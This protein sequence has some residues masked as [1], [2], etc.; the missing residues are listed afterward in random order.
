MVCSLEMYLSIWYSLWQEQHTRQN[1]CNV[2]DRVT[3]DYS[4][5]LEHFFSCPLFIEVLL[6]MCPETIY[7]FIYNIITLTNSMAPEP[8]GSSPHSQQPANGPYPEPGESTPHTHTHTSLPKVHFYPILPSTSWSSKWS[9]SFGISHQNP[10]HVSLLSHACHMSRLPYSPLFDLLN[11]VSWW[12]QIMKLS[13]LQLSPLSRYFIPL[14]SK[15]SPQR[16]V[17]KHPQFMI[18]P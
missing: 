16:P 7:T 13:F 8:E 10:I 9:F 3:R 2:R 5:C 12:V 11:T 1:V 15:Y 6:R 17:L 14:R 18:F 4:T